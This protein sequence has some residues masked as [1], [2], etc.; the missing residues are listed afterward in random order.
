M[1]YRGQPGLSVGVVYDQSLVWGAG[2]GLADIERGTPTDTETIYRIASLTKLFTSTAI[3]QLRDRGLLQL[4][5]PVKRHLPWF[6]I[7][8]P[9]PDSP[10]ITIRHLLTHASGLPREAAFPYWNAGELG[11]FPSRDQIQ[12]TVADQELALPPASNWK[13]SNL[14]LT[15]AGQ[16]VEAVAGIPY[17]DYVS[18]QILRPLGMKSTAVEAIDPDHPR[19]AAG[20][21]RRL[22]NGTREISPY[23]DCRGIGPAANMASSVED[24]ARFMM[25]QFRDGPRNRGKQILAG[26]T[27]RE[28]QRVHWLNEDWSAGAAWAST[29]GG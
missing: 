28:M 2:Y 24:L 14:G 26:S 29:S 15:L 6:S 4:D 22:P 9:Y 7:R 23:T 19:F 13:Y 3:M 8:N 18:K 21:G 16:I 25:L 17:A 1:A 5:D 11:E 27:L 20:Y 10:Q 12:A